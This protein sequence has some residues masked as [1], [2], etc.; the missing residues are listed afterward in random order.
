[1]PIQLLLG[2]SQLRDLQLI[3]D[4]GEEKL[5]KAVTALEEFKP[6]SLSPKCLQE[7]L[8]TVFPGEKETSISFLRILISFYNILR[9]RQIGID[10]LLEGIFYSINNAPKNFR[11]DENGLRKWKETE[12]FLKKLLSI[13]AVWN[14]VKALDLSYEYENLLQ[15]ARII[16]DI[17]PIFD[18]V[19]DKIEGTVITHT[20]RLEFDSREKEASL[21]IVLDSEDIKKLKDSCDRALKKAK[22]AQEF[23][24]EKGG[25]PSI[26]VG[27]M[28][29]D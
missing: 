25:K 19:A 17:R 9:Q 15:S 16:T 14:I 20:L 28:I 5:K 3:R 29:D 1:M 22:V 18:I 27:E 21:S 26:I 7:E 13:S 6:S 12:K 8:Y 24:T 23:V 11:W 4:I 10:A 2:E